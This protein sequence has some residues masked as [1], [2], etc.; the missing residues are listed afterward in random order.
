MF[1][2]EMEGFLTTEVTKA[3]KPEEYRQAYATAKEAVL[4][5][6]ADNHARFRLTMFVDDVERFLREKE[7]EARAEGFVDAPI[8]GRGRRVDR[9]RFNLFVQTE[10]PGT[11]RMIY[12]LRYVG[13]DGKAY[14][15]DGFKVVRDDEGLDLWEDNTTLFTSIREGDEKGPIVAQGMLRIGV[16]AF[17]RLLSTIKVRNSPGAG[18]SGR[19][20]ARFGRF[21]LGTLWETYVAPKLGGA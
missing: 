15:L 14:C 8:G 10:E 9:G 3:T 17:L 1:T 13:T 7:H 19:A 21:F 18:A 5:R 4:G 12:L 16:P 20:L 11:R 2:E 6:K